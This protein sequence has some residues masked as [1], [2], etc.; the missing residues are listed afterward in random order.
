MGSTEQKLFKSLYHKAGKTIH[1][2]KL[3]DPGDRILVGLSGG[4]DSLVLLEI[5]KE[6][7]RS[8]PFNFSI[9][10]VHIQV[11]DSGYEADHD[12]LNNFCKDLDIP[13]ETAEITAGID[14]SSRKGPCFLCSWHRRKKIFELTRT[15]NCNKLCF[16]HHRDDAL[17]TFLINML[18]H[19]SIS[20]L[21][22]K[23]KMFDGRV[24]LIRPM[25]DIWEEQISEYAAL[26][27]FPIPV[28]KCKYE[29]ESK[30]KYVREILFE[31]EKAYKKSKINMFRA[32]SNI[33]DEY[34]PGK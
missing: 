26:K 21:P 19:G 30:R 34:L 13:L 3:I 7:Q 5:L 33:Y 8:L 11:I 16:G 32:M 28:K 20:S 9:L 23:L 18:Y 2:H 27:N 10:A 17:E 25:L 15:F 6:K 4:K 29:D 31:F 12:F 1:Q 22:Y 24:H 14:G